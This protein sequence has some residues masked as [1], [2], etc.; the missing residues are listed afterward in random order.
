MLVGLVGMGIGGMFFWGRTP[1]YDMIY[2]R[3]GFL[4]LTY[5]ISHFIQNFNNS[6]DCDKDTPEGFLSGVRG[7]SIDSPPPFALGLLGLS[8][9]YVPPQVDIH[10][11]NTI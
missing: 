1:C 4:M 2:L 7:V 3:I 10:T 11:N 9:L 5:F 6:L 8:C